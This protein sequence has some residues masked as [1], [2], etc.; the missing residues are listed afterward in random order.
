MAVRAKTETAP[1]NL[2]A[3]SGASIPRGSRT[4]GA[5]WTAA[6]GPAMLAAIYAIF[7]YAPDERVMGAVQKIF[8]FHVAS[9]WNAFLAFLV[10]FVASVGY[11]VSRRPAWDQLAFASAEVGEVFTTITLL[12]GPL[13]GK[14]AWN[15]WWDWD[16]RL[17]TTLVLWV[18]YGVYLVAR[19]VGK[20]EPVDEGTKEPEASQAAVQV[21]VLGIVGFADIPIL[22]MSI[23]WW[24][25]VHP[26]LLQGAKMN[27][28]PPMT[29]TLGISVAAFTLLYLGLLGLRLRLERAR[30]EVR[31]LL[32]AGMAGKGV[33]V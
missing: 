20:G 29:W 32:A 7:V 18:I 15:I 5:F 19:H 21:A 8:Y 28:A 33:E 22:L 27:I 24:R 31:R 12:T 14:V 25:S 4:S 1:R 2:P 17:T 13:W 26:V 11:L 23:K 9:A 30:R 10:M 6:M 16:P 3:S